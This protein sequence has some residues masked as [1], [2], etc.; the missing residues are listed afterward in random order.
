MS[1]FSRTVRLQGGHYRLHKQF[2]RR[3]A[4]AELLHLIA[5]LVR[6]R[7]PQIADRRPR[8]QLEVTV[9][10]AQASADELKWPSSLGIVRVALLPS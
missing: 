4:V 3:V 8:R 1:G 7:Q 6:D 10:L 5:K 2:N 9:S